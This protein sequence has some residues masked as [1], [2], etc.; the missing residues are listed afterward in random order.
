[1]RIE[2][3]QSA[4]EHREPDRAARAREA[5]SIRCGACGRRCWRCSCRVNA[6]MFGPSLRYRVDERASVDGAEN[7]ELVT[8]AGS[9]RCRLH[10][11]PEGNA[12]IVWVFGAGGGWGGPAG[13]IYERLARVLQPEG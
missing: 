5:Y 10:A 6:I 8:D 3:E 4:G 12:G 1:M 11:A 13:G 9:I 7:L 2:S